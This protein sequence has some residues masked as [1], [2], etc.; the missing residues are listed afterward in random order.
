MNNKK[1]SAF[2]LSLVAAVLGAVGLIFYMINCKTSYF[3]NLG[4][5]SRIVIFLVLSVLLLVCRAV[6]E[7]GEGNVVTDLFAVVPPVLM[8]LSTIWFIASR[9]NG[10]AAIMTFQNNA[11]NMSDLSSA[12]IA[13]VLLLVGTILAIITA[14][15]PVEKARKVAV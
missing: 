1:G 11:Q 9:V 6:L 4:T 3:T 10:I 8:M 13:I 14:F 12:I 15:K 2:I 7:K 5:D